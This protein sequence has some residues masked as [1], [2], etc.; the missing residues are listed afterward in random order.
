MEKF[1][2]KKIVIIL[3]KILVVFA[4]LFMLSFFL[5]LLF[6]NIFFIYVLL[7]SLVISLSSRAISSRKSIKDKYSK[8]FLNY[9]NGKIEKANTLNEFKD[10]LSEFEELAIEDKRYNLSF[11]YDLKY[12]HNRILNSIEVL[13]KQIKQTL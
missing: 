13:E 8:E 7:A 3:D 1:K 10:I 2:E 11:P 6:E 9:I 5:T 12:T 4:I